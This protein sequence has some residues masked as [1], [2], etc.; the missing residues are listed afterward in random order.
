[1]GFA[2]R[3]ILGLEVSSF[4]VMGFENFVGLKFFFIWVLSLGVLDWRVGVRGG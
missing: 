1:M 2:F 4:R 3:L